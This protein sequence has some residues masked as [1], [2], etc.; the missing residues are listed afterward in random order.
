MQSLQRVNVAILN[1]H[2]HRRRYHTPCGAMWCTGAA[3]AV[4]LIVDSLA[5]IVAST[6]ASAA[7][8]VAAAAAAAAAVFIAMWQCVSVRVC[9]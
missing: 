3:A 9:V 7:P 4:A 8:A 1:V 6:A 5:T 2:E